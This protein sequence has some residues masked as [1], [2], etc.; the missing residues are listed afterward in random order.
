MQPNAAMWFHCI[1]WLLNTKAQISVKT[2][3]DMHS[4][5]ILSCMRLNGPPFMSEPILFAGTIAEYSKKA[6]PHDVR[7]IRISGHPS[8]M[9]NSDSL[10][11]PYHAKVMNMLDTISRRIVQSP[12][13]PLKFRMRR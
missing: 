4:W 7:M 2:V 13:M 11:C 5:M 10:S 8:L 3:R 9:C 1:G 12:C 6:I